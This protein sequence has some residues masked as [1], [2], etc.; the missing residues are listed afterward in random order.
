M[1]VRHPV[2]EQPVVDR[3]R[4][5]PRRMPTAP[6]VGV[7]ALLNLLDIV[8]TQ[9]VLGRG[10]AEGN[11]LMEPLIHGLWGAIALKGAC[12]LVIALLVARCG[13]SVRAWR[14]LLAVN[15]WYAVVVGWNLSILLRI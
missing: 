15:A 7:L 12:L 10:G 2:L 13:P 5:R 14:A 9:V 8:S 4:A 6:L 11:P 1:A 3:G